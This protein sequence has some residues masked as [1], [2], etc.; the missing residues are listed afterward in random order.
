[1]VP[2]EE[3]MEDESADIIDLTAVEAV[4]STGNNPSTTLFRV[5][6]HFSFLAVLR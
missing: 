5:A 1:M 4:V 3:R 6:D 2:M